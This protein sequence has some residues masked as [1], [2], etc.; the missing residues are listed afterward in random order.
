MTIARGGYIIAHNLELDG[1]LFPD[2]CDSAR[3]SLLDIAVVKHPILPAKQSQV[4]NNWSA[5]CHFL[6]MIEDSLEIL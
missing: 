1:I 2:L 5:Q 6:P 4:M 3:I